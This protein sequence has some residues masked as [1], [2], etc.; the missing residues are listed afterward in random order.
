MQTFRIKAYCQLITVTCMTNLNAQKSPP[1]PSNPSLAMTFEYLPFYDITRS[2]TMDIRYERA[3]SPFSETLESECCSL[4]NIFAYKRELSHQR[5]SAVSFLLCS[6]YTLSGKV[7]LR[8]TFE[9]YSTLF[10]CNISKLD[11]CTYL[12]CEVE[13]LWTGQSS[14][15]IGV[16]HK[17]ISYFWKMAS[18]IRNRSFYTLKMFH[19]NISLPFLV[20][21]RA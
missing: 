20:M 11:Y 6:V 19:C 14:W 18:P 2:S 16:F 17:G 7:M 15:E 13:R 1:N 21:E 4:T 10:W 8:M 9:F 12:H 3:C 5:L